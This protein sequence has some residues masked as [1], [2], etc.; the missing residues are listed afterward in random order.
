MSATAVRSRR[1]YKAR[2]A[3]RKG[4][5]RTTAS[6]IQWDRVGRIAL[7]LVVFLI[8]ASYVKPTINLISTWRESKAAEQELAELKRENAK[9]EKRAELLKTPAAAMAEARKLGMV[10]PGEQ[11]FKVSGLE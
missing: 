2:V 4:Q 3:P 5:G 9:L 10:G 7:V 1:R 8:L 6:R 11:A